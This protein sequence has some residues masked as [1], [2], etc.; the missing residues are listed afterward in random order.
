MPILDA[1]FS[2]D[3]TI[4][5]LAH[6]SVI[7][8]WD[9]EKNV[10]LKALDGGLSEVRQIGFVGDDG[11]YLAASAGSRGLAVWDLLS[12]EGKLHYLSNCDS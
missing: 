10:L 2:P 9:V 6:G 11:R 8:L 3:S 1:V 5:A 12:C 7:T 4:L